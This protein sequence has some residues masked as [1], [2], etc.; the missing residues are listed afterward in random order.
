MHTYLE[1]EKPIAEL[2]GKVQE[3]KLLAQEDPTAG[4]SDDVSKLEAKAAQLLK[5]MYANL[6]TWQKTQVARHPNRPHFLDYANALIEDFT[7]LAG[8]RNFGEDEAIVGGLGRFRGRSV[9]IMG[10]EKGND[11]E[12]RMKHNF[13]MAQPE[14][15][16][17][18]VRLMEMADRFSMPVITL[19]DTA[20]AFPGREGEE[21]GQAEAIARSI[22]TCLNVQ[23][24][25]V[26]LVIGEGGSGGALAIAT[27]SRVLM[28][29]HSIYTVASPEASASILWRN[30]DKAKDAAAAMKVTAQSL[31]ELGVIDRILPEPVGGAH[32]ER[33]QM[34]A[35][36][37]DALEHELRDMSGLDGASLR[38]Q[39][40]EKFMAIGRTGVS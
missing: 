13:G 35:D 37:G 10:H 19:I 8:D 34:M 29:E 36:V 30:S 3:L 7:P 40:Q 39:R 27:A 15:Y 14:G 22:D 33:A 6:D 25:F 11:V 4:I 24:P 5:D 21:R 16:R 31:L 23:V 9:V 38:R 26:S 1:F 32:R 2:E 28:L 18:A 12:T 17:K 20:G